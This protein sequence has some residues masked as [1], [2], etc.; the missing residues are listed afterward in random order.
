MRPA[1]RQTRYLLCSRAIKPPSAFET[2]RASAASTSPRD[3]ARRARGR[4][5][6]GQR[7]PPQAHRCRWRLLREVRQAD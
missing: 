1:G 6:A 3:T 4:A 5:R 2:Q 7:T